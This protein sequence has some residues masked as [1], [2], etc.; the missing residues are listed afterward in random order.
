MTRVKGRLA[1]GAVSI[2]PFVAIVSSILNESSEKSGNND[3]IVNTGKKRTPSRVEC[4]RKLKAGE[5]FD[6]LI[7]GAGATGAGAALDAAARGLKVA[8]VE[9]EDFASGTSSRSTKLIWAGSRYLVNAIVNLFNK[10]LRLLRD[11]V[12]TVTKFYGEWKMVMNCHRERKFLL[13]TNVFLI[14]FDD[15]IV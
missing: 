3:E 9:R 12:G 6:L 7:V 2:I 8:C 1:L 4:L 14:L 5:E 11:P 13:E 10:D 15:L